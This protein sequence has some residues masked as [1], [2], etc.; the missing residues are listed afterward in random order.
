MAAKYASGEQTRSIFVLLC[1][2]LPFYFH[3]SVAYLTTLSVEGFF[4]HFI[5]RILVKLWF[6]PLSSQWGGQAS[7]GAQFNFNDSKLYYTLC[8]E[9]PNL[10]TSQEPSSSL[11]PSLFRHRERP[12]NVNDIKPP[13]V[14]R[15]VL[16]MATAPPGLMALQN[17]IQNINHESPS[18]SA[19]PSKALHLSVALLKRELG[20]IFRRYSYFIHSASHRLYERLNF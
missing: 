10:K 4:N 2:K 1:S 5:L 6:I 16:L 11:L 15:A 17:I 14:S 3:S 13:L 7:E 8:P 19:W 20:N 12:R 9:R 18:P